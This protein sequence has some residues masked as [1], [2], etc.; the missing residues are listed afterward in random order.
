MSESW[1][2]AIPPDQQPVKQDT[3]SKRLKSPVPKEKDYNYQSTTKGLVDLL[4]MKNTDAAPNNQL[5]ADTDAQSKT[6]TEMT[7]VFA[8]F[9]AKMKENAHAA[10][11]RKHDFGQRIDSRTGLVLLQANNP[12]EICKYF[13]NGI[14]CTNDHCMRKHICSTCHRISHGAHEC[15]IDLDAAQEKVNNNWKPSKETKFI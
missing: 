14:D 11:M 2:A 6:P 5:K 15:T 10:A 7:Q 1:L 8:S 12:G 13:N 4:L 9:Q 3:G